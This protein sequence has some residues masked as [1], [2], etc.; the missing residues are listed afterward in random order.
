MSHKVICFKR[1]YSF[2]QAKHQHHHHFKE[3]NLGIFWLRRATTSTKR[4][5]RHRNQSQKE[6]NL[7]EQT[8]KEAKTKQTSKRVYG[9]FYGSNKFQPRTTQGWKLERR[10][11]WCFHIIFTYLVNFQLCVKL[12]TGIIYFLSLIDIATSVHVIYLL[13]WSLHYNVFIYFLFI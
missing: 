3:F 11:M 8:T 5:T 13:Q 10:E 2:N 12:Y 1:E 9:K 4:W 7:A 6:L